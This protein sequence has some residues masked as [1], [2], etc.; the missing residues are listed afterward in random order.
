[1]NLCNDCVPFIKQFLQNSTSIL[2]VLLIDN[3]TIERIL[4]LIVFTVEGNTIITEREI[5]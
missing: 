5:R 1:M 3:I 4:T 2:F